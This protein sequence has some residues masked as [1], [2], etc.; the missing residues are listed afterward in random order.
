MSEKTLDRDPM[1]WKSWII[2]STTE[3]RIA[4]VI[5]RKHR[6]MYAYSVCP[7]ADCD[8]H[9]TTDLSVRNNQT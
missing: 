8:Q 1:N 4:Q 5:A 6:E 3:D 7:V 9:P 2:T